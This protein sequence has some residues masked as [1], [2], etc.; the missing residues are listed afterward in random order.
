MHLTTRD[1]RTQADIILT[2]LNLTPLE[3]AGSDRQIRADVTLQVR[4]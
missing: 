2:E 3:I 4:Y 1:A